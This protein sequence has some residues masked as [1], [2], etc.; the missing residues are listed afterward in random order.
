MTA[1][2]E[3]QH[4][5]HVEVAL[6][7]LL[8]DD[9]A[10]ADRTLKEGDSAYHACG[11]GISSFIASMLGGEKELLKDAATI[12]QEAETRT[13]DEMKRAQR[14]PTAFRSEIYPPGTEYLLC[15]SSKGT[16]MT[17]WTFSY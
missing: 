1:A 15:F 16:V 14:E 9:V 5:Q 17:A 4:L 12:L 10:G 8:N 6:L 2:E 11:R 13:W 3:D 7:Q